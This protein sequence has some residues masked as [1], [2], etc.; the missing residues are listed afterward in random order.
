MKSIVSF[1]VLSSILPSVYGH[2]VI[3]DVTGANGVST[4]GFGVG[5]RTGTNEQPFQIDTP[6][7]KDLT[8]D[9]C[10]AT[11]Q[12]GSINIA[13][14]L[15][16]AISQGGG[17]LPSLSANGSITFT[18]HQVNADGGG[19]FT[20]MVNTDATG[21]TW[22]PATVT[23]NAPGSNGIVTGGPVDSVL[24]AQ[25]PS[26]TACTGGSTG[27]VCL[28]RL[29]NGGAGQEA[30]L[31]NG[32]GPFGGCAAVI[33]A[34][35]AA[36]STITSAPVTATT[37]AAGTGKS[38]KAAKAKAAKA[39]KIAAAKAKAAAAAGV[40]ARAERHARREADMDDLLAK[41]DALDHEIE[42]NRRVLV[43]RQK[44]T[45]DLID[46]IKTATGTAVNIPIDNF[47]G[48]NDQSATGGNSSTTAGAP[49]TLQQAVDLEK[50]V[51]IE[52]ALDVLAS[53][54]VTTAGFQSGKQLTPEEFVGANDAANAALAD[55]TLTSVNLGNAG[56]TD[57]NTSV[58]N[59]LLG[60]I[61][62]LVTITGAPLF[63]TTLAA[64]AA[65]VTTSVAASE[66]GKA[67]KTTAS[68]VVTAS[69]VTNTAAA[70][71]AKAAKKNKRGFVS[72]IGR[73][74]D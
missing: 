18:L 22:E 73:R 74:M 2:A 54:Q 20:A 59:A 55:G 62:D 61:S 39:A 48:Q 41:R 70:T 27:N 15:T 24:I 60:G 44:L 46:A 35:G 72:R 4:M 25:L 1:A 71:A 5:D 32:A 33:N 11:L 29:S 63:T 47:A 65:T 53:G 50:A 9:P 64:P 23:Q 17:D 16:T 57:P 38:S 3:I 36:A 37:A 34:G 58:V 19:P 14:A 6:V 26:G 68:A 21:K 13:K 30:S 45:I 52:G 42:L 40:N 7:L 10:G 43:A 67:G 31:A 28:V 51:A 69:A 8:T 49:L 66:A 56:V 12:S